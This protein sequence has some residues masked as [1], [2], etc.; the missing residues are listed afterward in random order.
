M[1]TKVF[2]R[3]NTST[4]HG[5]AI[6][7]MIYHH[8]FINGNRWCINERTSLFDIFEFMNFYNDASVQMLIAWFC[9][10][11]VAVFA[12]TSGYG[13]YIQLNRK[14]DGS[15]R[16]IYRYCLSRLWSFYKKFL[17]AFLFFNGYQILFDQSHHF[18]Y[19]LPNFIL[20]MLGLRASY[21]ATLW[22]IPVYYCMI[23]V[24]PVLYAV[25]EGKIRFRLVVYLALTGVCATVGILVYGYI[26]NDLIHYLKTISNLIQSPLTVYLFV[27]LEGMICA[28]NMFLEKMHRKMNLLSST[29]LLLATFLL[30][31][32]VIRVPGDYVF[33]VIFTVPFVLSITGL[34][35]NTRYIKDVFSFLGRYSSYIWYSHPYFY[36][37]L[38]FAL[39]KRSD[40]SFFVYIQVMLYSLLMSLLF[41]FIEAISDKLCKRVFRTKTTL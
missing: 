7:M 10:I 17:I 2:D 12:F 23:L 9:K 19:S 1:E 11:C 18:D 5:I 29:L 31:T 35:S 22:Y 36:S 20:N 25:L 34:F 14:C 41:S 8:L 40:I 28:K 27:F 24:S 26:V 32:V 15:Y 37:Y 38:F 3:K 39:V 16:S 21:N 33:D 30:R 13:I 4:L 6:S